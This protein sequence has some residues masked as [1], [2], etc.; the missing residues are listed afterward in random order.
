MTDFAYVAPPAEGLRMA[1]GTARTRRLRK[2]GASSSFMAAALVVLAVTAGTPGR[3]TLLQQP[4]PETPAF[5]E[6]RTV[7]AGPPEHHQTPSSTQAARFASLTTATGAAVGPQLS[8][9][10]TVLSLPR[11]A[12]PRASD[13][14]YRA[15]PIARSDG[16]VL[17]PSPD[18]KVNNDGTARDSSLCPSASAGYDATKKSY[19]L[20]GDICSG[21]P[22]VVEL[23]FTR[24]NE[25]DFA[26]ARNGKEVWRWSKNHETTP[27]PH[28]RSL[29]TGTCLGWTNT[30]AGVDNE[31][32]PLAAGNN[33]TLTVDYLTSA[34][35][36]KPSYTSSFTIS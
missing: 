1:M 17:F 21:N 36:D 32:H 15:A 31:G 25:V 6:Q 20:Y 19:N 11:Q 33:Y 30:W 3:S 16:G 24:D 18:C 34:M 14:R 12:V 4:A 8:P 10:S 9:T 23:T 2:A 35:Q 5:T 27:A 28:N 13:H 26:V 29:A 22:N 7:P